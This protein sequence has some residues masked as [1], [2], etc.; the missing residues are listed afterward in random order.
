MASE[1]PVFQVLEYAEV[2]DLKSG[3]SRGMLCIIVSAA[4]FFLSVF[5]AFLFNAIQNIRKDPDAMARLR[6]KKRS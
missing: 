1:S 4:G 2:P 3:P 5:L 6:G